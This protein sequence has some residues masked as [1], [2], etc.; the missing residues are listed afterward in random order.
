VGW[1]AGQ[2]RSHKHSELVWVD[3]A[4][5]PPGT[6]AVTIAVERGDAFTLSAQEDIA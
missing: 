2:R 1:R 3:P 5:L 6:A 4:H